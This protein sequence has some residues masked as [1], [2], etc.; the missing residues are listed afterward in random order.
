MPDLLPIAF[1]DFVNRL[2]NPVT[3][4]LLVIAGFVF[5]LAAYRWWTRP[6]IFWS[7]LA[8]LFLLLLAS[9]G[10][11]N[12]K[13]IVGK[14]DNVPIVAMLFIV[15]F[16]TWLSLR[17]AAIN[18]ERMEK[19]LP[20]MEEEEKHDRVLVW[21]D[22]VFTEFLSAIAFTILLIVW[23]ML[24]DA[25]L[26]DPADAMATPNPSK[27]PWYFLGLQ[28]MLV[29]FDPWL[30]GVVL[31]GMIISGLI[32]IPYCDPNPRGNGYYTLRERPFAIAVFLFGFL[33]L[34]ISLIFMGTALRGPNWNFFGPYEKWDPHKLVP[35]NNINLSQMFWVDLLGRKLPAEPLV[36]ELPGILLVAGYLF[37]T[38]P[39]LLLIPA[40]RNLYS[41]M[42]F[43]RYSLMMVHLL[44]MAGMVF[45]MVL[46]WTFNLK[47]IVAIER[48]N[49]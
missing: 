5:L 3:Y 14:G 32:L 1:K 31:P 10:D 12:F 25:P 7:V 46:R 29:Y 42:G 41:R 45:K 44:V 36:R 15:F 13:L 16:F 33:V 26:E 19:G 38:P 27:A 23:S 37:L 34:W 6:K 18:D 9:I 17:Q 49:I 8:A 43:V 28:E 39:L 11:P 21:P 35:L 48:Y 22:L 4:T 40:V 24:V 2:F 30:A 20:T 47:Y